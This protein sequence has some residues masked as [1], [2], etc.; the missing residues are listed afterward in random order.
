MQHR[1]PP[2]LPLSAIQRELSEQ[3]SLIIHRTAARAA[4]G[5]LCR[6]RAREAARHRVPPQLPTAI[7]AHR[8][9][10][11]RPTTKV[12]PRPHSAPVLLRQTLAS[13]GR[14]PWGFFESRRELTE[15]GEALLRTVPPPSHGGPGIVISRPCTCEVLQF[16]PF[17]FKLS[18]SSEVL[19][20]LV[21]GRFRASLQ[22]KAVLEVGAGLG[23][24]GIA[25]AAWTECASLCITDGDPT[26]VAALRRN[27]ELNAEARSFGS[28]AVDAQ[29]LRYG[30]DVEKDGQ[31]RLYD[32]IL[33]AD[34]VYDR[35]FHLP[36]CTTL[37]RCLAPSGR[38]LLVASTRCGSLDDFTRACAAHFVVERVQPDAAI[39]NR[40]RGQKCFP[41]VLSLRHSPLSDSC[42]V[43]VQ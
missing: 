4:A 37:K 40:F 39:I 27:V 32:C 29:M 13:R 36:L 41:K 42:A 33:C 22:G 35:E 5:E 28:T 34:C 6:R 3:N 18:P 9:P 26:S 21:L 10:P 30:D 20:W 15:G 23:Y 12:P 8:P 16:G 25:C 19:A 7:S 38:V 43:D 1:A 11:V 2:T 17:A 14:S 31:R 24:T